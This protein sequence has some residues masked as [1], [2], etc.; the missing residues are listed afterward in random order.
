MASLNNTWKSLGLDL[1]SL[2]VFIATAEEC[3]LAKAAVRENIAHSA[4]SRRITDLESRAGVQLFERHDRGVVLTAAGGMLLEQ[5]RN[6]AQLLD[7]IALDLEEIR[8]GVRGHVRVDANMSAVS[9][10]LPGKIA[11]FLA[12]HPGIDIELN[13]HTSLDILHAVRTGTTD[14]GFVSGTV[15]PQGLQ[16]IPWQSDELVGIL[17]P[18][19]E[20]AAK[21]DLELAD[22]LS[23]PF[24]G[25][26]RD[27]ALLALYRTHAKAMGAVLRERVHA[28][29][30]DTVRNL[31]AAGLGVAI[32]PA[33]VV[34][35]FE[36][37]L[38]FEVRSLRE[39]WALRPLVLCVRDIKRLSAAGRLLIDHLTQRRDD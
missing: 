30:F 37:S 39:S 12:A 36:A 28:A 8:G 16:L 1:V 15:D 32:L 38:G 22:L 31:V 29:S 3:S 24:I 14:I 18:G 7:R 2:R 11:D 13:E 6:V 19:H 10:A 27:S 23:Y 20:L 17:P 5:F 4:V 9:G 21:T 34:R 33:G 35:P 25:M 26:Q